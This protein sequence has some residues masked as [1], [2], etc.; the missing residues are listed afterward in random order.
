MVELRRLEGKGAGG[1]WQCLE[2][3][4]DGIGIRGQCQSLALRMAAL[5]FLI[6]DVMVRTSFHPKE[7]AVTAVVFI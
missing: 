3:S 2:K 1:S 7:K 5:S 6:L 4:E